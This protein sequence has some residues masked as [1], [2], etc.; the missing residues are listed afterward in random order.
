MMVA[1]GFNPRLE[2]IEVFPRRVATPEKA[3]TFRGRYATT[4]ESRT[5]TAG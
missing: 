3:E 2:S 4:I 5:T 1:V